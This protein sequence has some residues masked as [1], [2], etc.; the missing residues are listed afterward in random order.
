MTSPTADLAAADWCYA[1]DASLT[2]YPIV[3]NVGSSFWRSERQGNYAIGVGTTGEIVED[4]HVLPGGWSLCRGENRMLEGFETPWPFDPDR[5]YNLQNLWVIHHPDDQNAANDRYPGVAGGFKGTDFL[6]GGKLYSKRADPARGWSIGAAFAVNGTGIS[7]GRNAD[8]RIE[9]LYTKADGHI[10]HRFQGVP[11][12]PFQGEL[13]LGGCAQQ[14]AIGYNADGR[15]ELFYISSKDETHVANHIYHRFQ[16]VPNGPFQGELD[17]GGCAQQIAIGYN[18]DGRMELF[19]ISSKDETHVANH[20]YHRFQGVPNGPFQGE[21]DLGGCAQQIAIGYNADGRMELFYISSKDETHVAN[22][23]YHRFQGVPNGPFQGE[24]DLGGCAQQIAI[25]R[26]ADGRMELF[27]IASDADGKHLANHIYRRYQG[28]PN[29]P[30]QDEVGPIGEVT[31]EQLSLVKTA[32][33]SMAA[34]IAS[35]DDCSI[36]WLDD[37]GQFASNAKTLGQKVK[38]FAIESNA[39]GRLEFFELH[40]NGDLN[41][42]WQD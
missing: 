34:I 38:Q 24:L 16:G 13:D 30:F 33:G 26:H 22:H 20:I 3:K 32:R 23:I 11:N 21:L 1:V 10:Y 9:A 2:I 18:A 39:D 41:H 19:Y 27:Y 15:M 37:L 6:A 17:L 12:G 8:G 5:Q 31:A 42:R 25:G 36:Y 40:V 29:G 7:V 35:A 4:P 28:V 14:I